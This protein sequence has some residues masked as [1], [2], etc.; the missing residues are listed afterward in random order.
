MQFLP[1]VFPTLAIVPLQTFDP[2]VALL[3]AAGVAVSGKLL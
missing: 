2:R 1:H 3:G